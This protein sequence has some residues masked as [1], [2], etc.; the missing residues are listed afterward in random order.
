MKKLAIISIVL[1]IIAMTM[2]LTAV[3]LAAGIQNWKLDSEQTAAG[4]QMERTTGSGN[5]GQ[6]GQVDIAS[7]NCAIWLADEA[8]A[9]DVTFEKG[10]WVA[11]L[12]TEVDWTDCIAV[13]IGEWDGSKFTAFNTVTKVSFGW[14]SGAIVVESQLNSETIA[15]GNYLA[16]E[17]CNLSG[18]E[19]TAGHTIYT[20]GCSQLS[21]PC[22]DPGY[23][24]P[25]IAAGALF[26]MGFLGLVGYLGI[27]W[28]KGKRQETV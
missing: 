12:C 3:A 9:Q 27:K 5:D 4:Y 25:E 18:T 6:S 23:P 19:C 8:A 11:N 22:E 28:L 20:N 7:G 1:L 26:G 17:I 14:A 15:T 24:F 21:S 10:K 16:L 13:Q 2:S